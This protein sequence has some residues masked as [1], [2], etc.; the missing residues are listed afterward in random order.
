MDVGARDGAGT[1]NYTN[2]TV[3]GTQTSLVNT[4]QH[5]DSTVAGKGSFPRCISL[6]LFIRTERVYCAMV[7][8][9]TG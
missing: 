9:I 1:C 5:N 7:C 8:Y 6:W 2:R 4:V 3:D